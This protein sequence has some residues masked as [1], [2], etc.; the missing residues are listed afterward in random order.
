[1]NSVIP[2]M[3]PPSKQEKEYDLHSAAMPWLKAIGA[4][5]VPGVRVRYVPPQWCNL[6]IAEHFDGAGGC[7]GISNG[8]VATGGMK[9]CRSCDY[10]SKNWRKALAQLVRETRAYR[11]ARTEGG[12]MKGLLTGRAERG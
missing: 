6:S 2:P 9:Y 12:T 8:L 7:W 5:R 4:T 11:R 10:C 3:P 1:M